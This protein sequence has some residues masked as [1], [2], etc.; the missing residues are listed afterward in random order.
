MIPSANLS[1]LGSPERLASG[2]T[3]TEGLPAAASP[4]HSH[5]APPAARATKPSNAAAA[6]APSAGRTPRQSP[7]A[8]RTAVQPHPVGP[9]RPGDVL[10]L[11]LA[12]ELQRQ[13]EPA[14]EVVVG[15][16][17]DQHA[18]GLAQLLQ[19]GGDVD[20]VAEQ[21]VALDHHVAEVDAD[22]EHDAPVGRR[23]GLAVGHRLLDRDRAGD[24]VDHARRTRRSRRRPSA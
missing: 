24:R 17:G 8:H 21:V 9:H 18:A 2:S 11:L 10:D 12:G 7:A 3:A 6:A 1:H 13:P 5:H 16:A 22:A 15:G 4:G 19:A 14:L 23:L 20:P